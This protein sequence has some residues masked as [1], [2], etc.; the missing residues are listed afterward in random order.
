V[1][2]GYA[3]IAIAAIRY[4]RG[5]GLGSQLWLGVLCLLFATL[6]IALGGSARIPPVAAAALPLVAGLGL[7][8][9][10]MADRRPD[11]GGPRLKR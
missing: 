3:F 4:F 7:A 6:A 9:L 8:V 5:G 10:P 1:V 11:N 2:S